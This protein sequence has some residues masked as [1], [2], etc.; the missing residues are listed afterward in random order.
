MVYISRIS[1]FLIYRLIGFETVLYFIRQM[2]L[3]LPY[4][5]AGNG[6]RQ[7]H[8]HFFFD[9]EPK[10]ILSAIPDLNAKTK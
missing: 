4:K 3:F 10:Q 1:T 6:R 2:T 9:Y 8:K 5:V 7:L